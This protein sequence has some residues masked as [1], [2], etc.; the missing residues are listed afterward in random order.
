MSSAS[1]T[2]TFKNIPVKLRK[3]KSYADGFGNSN[4]TNFLL[5]IFDDSILLSKYP[6]IF[7]IIEMT[8][9]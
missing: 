3:R 5:N 7:K 2:K 1:A 6:S 4:P 9:F 8:I